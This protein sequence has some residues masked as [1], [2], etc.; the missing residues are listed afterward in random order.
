MQKSIGISDL[1]LIRGCKSGDLK[2]QEL[3]YKQFYGYAMGVGMRYLSNRDDAMEVVNDSFIKAFNGIK[4][5]NE[6]QPFR[7]WL[8]RIIVN[9]A[10][11]CHR[12]NLKH[13]NQED[14]DLVVNHGKAAE[15]LENL[16][17]KDILRLLDKLPEIHRTVFNMY[18]LDGFNHDEIADMLNIPVSSS[19]VYLSR[20]KDK[21]RAYILQ[22]QKRDYERA[23][24]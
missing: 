7:A 21:L 12:K 17:A 4:F 11:D 9:T 24:R 6:N 15:A 8:R 1:D 10:I 3:L 16:S 22:Q 13:Q 19:R 18:E 23:I 5:F 14:I 2:S 20:A